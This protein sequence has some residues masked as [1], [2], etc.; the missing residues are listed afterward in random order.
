MMCLIGI[1]IR[2]VYILCNLGIRSLVIFEFLD[3]EKMRNYGMYFP[4]I[5]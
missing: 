5:I 1:K 2:L 4:S 3:E